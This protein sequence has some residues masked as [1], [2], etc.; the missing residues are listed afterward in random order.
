MNSKSIF[1]LMGTLFFLGTSIASG[2]T[3]YTT[4]QA[5]CTQLTGLS[6][7]GC[8]G[9]DCQDM[10]DPVLGIYLGAR[11]PVDKNRILRGPVSVADHTS[12]GQS[13][14]SSG[15]T[16]QCVSEQD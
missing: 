9:V 6:S 5:T 2:Q 4:G 10:Y 1:V 7:Y 11:C 12:F 8:N 15:A 14:F 16:V 3:C 13:S